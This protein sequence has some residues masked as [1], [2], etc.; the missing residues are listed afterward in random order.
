MLLL[1]APGK[2][3]RTQQVPTDG[4]N[5]K[6]GSWHDGGLVPSLKERLIGRFVTLMGSEKQEG[7]RIIRR[8]PQTIP[9]PE[10][11][12]GVSQTLRP[13]DSITARIPMSLVTCRPRQTR[14]RTSN[15]STSN[16]DRPS[17]R[18]R[19]ATYLIVLSNFLSGLE[20]ST[21]VDHMSDVG[22]F[23]LFRKSFFKFFDDQ[24]FIFYW[25]IKAD[26]F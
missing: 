16:K 8:T 7:R 18:R 23:C 25:K 19:M 22:Y 24:I 26:P 5:F 3:G 12:L 6:P 10:W 13:T 20:L 9:C 14:V 15:R 21:P 11:N 2:M 17:L 1:A 4:R